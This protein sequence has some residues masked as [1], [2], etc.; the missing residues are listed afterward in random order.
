MAGRSGATLLLLLLLLLVMMGHGG[1]LRAA[2][3]S[4]VEELLAAVAAAA[5]GEVVEL[6]AG[7]FEL[8]GPLD[9]PGGV[10]LRGAGMDET[11]LT[12]VEG[13][14]AEHATLPDPETDHGRFDRSGYLVRL[15]DHGKD[16]EI[17]GMT[18]TGPAVHGAIFGWGNT[19]LVLHHLKIADFLYAGVRTYSTKR[20]KIHDCLFIDAGQRWER[21][22]PGVGGGITGG[23]IFVI[24]IEDSEIFNNRFLDTKAE[25][26]LH[27]Y[28]I[29]GR[30]GK[31]LKIHHNTIETNFAIEFPFENDEDVEISH[32]VLLG[33]VSIPKHEGG[34]VPESGRTFFIHHN[35]F[36]SSY[37]IEFM[38]NGVE[39]SH[40]L[41]DFDVEKDGGNLISAFGN[42]P[43]RGP[44]SFHNNLV[45]N[46]GRGV[47]WMDGQYRDLEIRN[48]H[49]IARTTATPRE[50]GLFGFPKGC[51][52]SGFRMVD[53]VIECEGIARPLFRNDESGEM[54]VENNRLVNVSDLGRYENPATVGKQGLEAPLK[55][56]CGV[57]GESEV[58]GWE[59][60]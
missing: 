40:N 20:A 53:N 11:V 42:V 46:P 21:G 28:G 59:L 54:V 6:G 25:P 50:D 39:I 16:N 12:H 9:L 18:L 31:R 51:D 60:R 10:G 41:F 13:W 30:Q 47:M 4:T 1:G 36:T 19:G 49:I 32:N 29:K 2:P 34:A 24:W 44:A 38:R 43:A 35:Y 57:D 15:A 26:N 7:R 8:E 45:S 56:R 17:S 37:A 55:F 5:E 22:R 48:N 14:R 3:V 58:D 33:T 27:Y 23:G 52:F